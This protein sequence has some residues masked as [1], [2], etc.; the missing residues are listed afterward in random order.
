MTD[1]T[2]GLP[3][4]GVRVLN[5]NELAEAVRIHVLPGEELTVI[6]IREGQEPD[7]GR[8]HGEGWVGRGGLGLDSWMGRVFRH[9]KIW[10]GACWGEMLDS[11]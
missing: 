9:W 5:I 11:I 1:S 4:Q 10:V 6:P 2:G 3:L 8:D 7:Q